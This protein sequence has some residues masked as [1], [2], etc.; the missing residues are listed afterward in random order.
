MEWNPKYLCSNWDISFPLQYTFG[1]N[2]CH[3]NTF[4]PSLT[5]PNLWRSCRVADQFVAPQKLQKI[6]T[7]LLP[8]SLSARNTLTKS[9]SCFLSSEAK[10]WTKDRLW[11]SF[12]SSE[13]NLTLYPNNLWQIGVSSLLWSMLSEAGDGNAESLNGLCTE[14]LKFLCLFSF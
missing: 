11:N 5:Q 14:Y 7:F 13:Q 6:T 12:Q 9:C 3:S 8:T 10:S 4:L 2:H 1:Q